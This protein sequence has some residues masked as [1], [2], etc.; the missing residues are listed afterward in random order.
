MKKTIT[1]IIDH[2]K[3]V[4]AL[5]EC[6]VDPSEEIN[7]EDC[8]IDMSKDYRVEIKSCSINED[9]DLVCHIKGHEDYIIEKERL[10][11]GDW[12]CHMASRVDNFGEFVI[13]Y[14]I[15]LIRAGEKE[16][17]VELLSDFENCYKFA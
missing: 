16:I 2:A 17:S 12:M 6:I 4:V 9:G 10:T 1:E 5:A 14:L 13:A 11:E 15:A 3:K 8:S 7:V